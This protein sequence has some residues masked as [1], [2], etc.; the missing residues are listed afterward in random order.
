MTTLTPNF[1]LVTYAATGG[2]ENSTFLDF[3]T[4]LA[5]V[6]NSNMTKIDTALATIEA[7]SEEGGVG[8]FINNGNS[9]ITTGLKLAGQEVPYNMTLS[10]WSVLSGDATTS[11]ACTIVIEKISYANYPGGTWTTV[12]TVSISSG[13]KGTG[14]NFTN[15]SLTKGDILKVTVSANTT[16]KKLAINLTGNKT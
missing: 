10:S 3:R 11:G 9:E 13:G 5:G 4:N 15:A 6:S 14:T 8:F 1:S 7:L 2:D 16:F 12:A